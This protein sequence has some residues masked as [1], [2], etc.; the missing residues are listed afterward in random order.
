MWNASCGYEKKNQL[1]K[2][3]SNDVHIWIIYHSNWNWALCS[4]HPIQTFC[5]ILSQ[6]IIFTW[7]QVKKNYKLP[8]TLL[9]MIKI[10]WSIQIAHL[11]C[12]DFSAIEIYSKLSFWYPF[13]WIRCVGMDH[14]MSLALIGAE[15]LT[16]YSP[17]M[18]DW[19]RLYFGR[20]SWIIQ[21]HFCDCSTN[22]IHG[23]SIE[24]GCCRFVRMS[25]RWLAA[26]HQFVVSTIWVPARVWIEIEYSTALQ[27]N[28]K[29]WI[30]SMN[31]N[32]MKWRC[33]GRGWYIRS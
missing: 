13:D 1:S 17:L 12:S 5:A 20:T 21:L 8:E 27:A 10:N 19:M 18:F 32:L 30:V 22:G 29:A 23:L 24:H 25:L 3:A 26:Q 11:G 9:L 31:A 7:C 16:I 14:T 33:I 6:C 15:W 4:T 2:L 28:V